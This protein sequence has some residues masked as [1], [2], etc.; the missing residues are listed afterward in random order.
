LGIIERHYGP[1]R[2][3]LTTCRIALQVPAH[4]PVSAIVLRTRRSHRRDV[5]EPAPAGPPAMSGFSSGDTDMSRRLG[6]LQPGRPGGRQPGR[7]ER[8]LDRI[9]LSLFPPPT[10][11][12][13]LRSPYVR[14]LGTGTAR[15]RDAAVAG[16]GYLD[17]GGDQGSP[18]PRRTETRPAATVEEGPGSPIGSVSG[19]GGKAHRATMR[20]ESAYLP[21]SE[22][23]AWRGA[24]AAGP[25]RAPAEPIARL[26]NKARRDAGGSG[27]SGS[28]VGGLGDV[29]TI[30]TNCM[31]KIL[32]PALPR[33]HTAAEPGTAPRR[34][35]YTAR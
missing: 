21:E 23:P 13:V 31:L 10:S 5:D 9:P 22:V 16:G 20:L 1:R 17:G 8:E 29:L 32:C 25:G 27:G 19:S 4:P 2:P 28:G 7:L 35:A 12:P 26:G 33:P 30:R 11:S 14:G 3:A 18:S 6:G 24:V 34:A 15:R